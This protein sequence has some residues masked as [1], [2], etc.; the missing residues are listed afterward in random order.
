MP[1]M[2]LDTSLKGLKFPNTAGFD[3]LQADAAN[4]IAE[5]AGA[6]DNRAAIVATLFVPALGWVAFN[7]LGP[8]LNQYQNMRLK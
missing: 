5:V 6:G 1:R 2:P 8:A 7:I 4:Q 3:K